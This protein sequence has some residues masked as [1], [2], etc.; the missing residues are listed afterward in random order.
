MSGQ[1]ESRLADPKKRIMLNSTQVQVEVEVA[2]EFGNKDMK[3]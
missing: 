2:V 1:V 3:I